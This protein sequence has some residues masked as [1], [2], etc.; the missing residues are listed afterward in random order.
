M[1]NNLLQFILVIISSVVLYIISTAIFTY[2]FLPLEQSKDYC[3]WYTLEWNENQYTWEVA[4]WYEC[5]S[6][7]NQFEA[8]IYQHN[9]AIVPYQ[10]IVMSILLLMIIKGLIKINNKYFHYKT[11]EWFWIGFFFVTF[12]LI[13]FLNP[14]T[15]SETYISKY[16][17]GTY[18]QNI[19]DLYKKKSIEYR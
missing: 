14:F 7:T 5:T 19:V 1:K 10:L 3:L 2:H 16:V 17:S 15:P 12:L 13:S 9:N 4:E 11:D 18:E 8:Y 6:F